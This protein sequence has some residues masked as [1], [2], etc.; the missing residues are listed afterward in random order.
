MGWIIRYATVP[1]IAAAALLSAAPA[2]A[3][4]AGFVRYLNEHG[5]T[6][7]Y[8]GGDPI[9]APSV[10]ALGHM[11]CENLHIGRSVEDQQPN[12]PAW[13]QFPL[14]ADAAQHELCP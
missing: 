6:A 4:D 3:D 5:Y 10:R 14:I 1:A 11:I 7:A 13:P 2:Y 12:Y 9:P 8:A